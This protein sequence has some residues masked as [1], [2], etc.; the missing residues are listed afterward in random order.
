MAEGG[1]GYGRQR[2]TLDGVRSVWQFNL[3]DRRA[4]APYHRG[5]KSS[6]N[7]RRQEP[8]NPRK[9]RY[10]HLFATLPEGMTHIVAIVLFGVASDGQGKLMANN[11]VATAFFN[12]IRLKGRSR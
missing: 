6:R 10:V 7:G 4:L 1:N 3:L 2:Q 12:H 9:Y 11:Y 8:L 5:R